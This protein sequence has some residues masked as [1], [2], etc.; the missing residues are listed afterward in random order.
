[1]ESMKICKECGQLMNY[2]SYFGGYYCASCGL[3]ETDTRQRRGN[4]WSKNRERAVPRKMKVI[5]K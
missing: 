5:A 2:N 3:L 4:V 1:M